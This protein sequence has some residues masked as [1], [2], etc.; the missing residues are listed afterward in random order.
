MQFTQQQIDLAGEFKNLGLPWEPSVGNYVYDGTGSVKPSSPFQDGVYFLLNYD[1]FT[2]RLGG[3]VRFKELMTWLPTWDDARKILK[4]FGVAD[5]DVQHELT[6]Q[7]SIENGTE[8][9]A[10][11]KMI[12]DKLRKNCQENRPI[13]PGRSRS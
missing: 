7:N 12:G 9:L 6:E 2:Q 10:L 11:Y 8:L 1:Y 3:V 4:S 13:S 5:K